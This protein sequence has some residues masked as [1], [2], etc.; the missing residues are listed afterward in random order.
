MKKILLITLSVLFIM[1][2]CND[3][4]SDLNKISK[5]EITSSSN[6]GLVVQD[7]I[8]DETLKK[9][10][11][12]VSNSPA[13]EFFPLTIIPSIKVSSGAKVSPSSGT[14]VVFN[15]ADDAV[16]YEVTAEDGNSETYIVQIIH[17]QIQ[18]SG[19]QDWYDVQLSTSASYKE[20]GRLKNTT[21]WASANS[22]TSTYGVYNTMP[23][24]DENVGLEDTM[25][26]IKTSVSG[27][28]PITAG[29][30]FTGRFSLAGA[31]ANPTDPKKATTFGIPYFWRPV[32]IKFKF[33]YTAGPDYIKATLNNPSNIF[34]GF[35]IDSLDGFDKC[36]I[37]AILE[38]RTGTETIEIGRADFI[39][40][41]SGNL[42]SEEMVDFTYTSTENPT[43]ITVVFTSS[44]D[45]D[46][47]TGAVGSELIV[48]N[49]ELIY[50]E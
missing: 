14:Q 24:V 48:N 18:N 43:H 34:G 11:I 39:S 1:Y 19:F 27:A 10:Y 44:K 26:L 15:D 2:S 32:S 41:T 42:L 21:L 20:A 28:I 8:I 38:K 33:K 6:S 5:Y 17:K 40:G 9:I 31:I 35:T 46:L 4:E 47:W 29:T 49:L 45:G 12:V 36:N 13:E 30:L 3:D 7:V 25:V 50:L 37:Y 22:G 23:Y 16:F